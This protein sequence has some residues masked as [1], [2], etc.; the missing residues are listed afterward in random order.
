[1][2]HPSDFF[3]LLNNWIIVT[4]FSFSSSLT[5]DKLLQFGQLQIKKNIILTKNFPSS[6]FM[7][8]KLLRELMQ[9]THTLTYCGKKK[10][11][12]IENVIK[13]IVQITFK[14]FSQN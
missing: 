12:Q 14:L 13:F 5:S 3:I 8:Y 6:Q 9:Y 10:K 7:T 11:K 4:E 1:M 2:Q